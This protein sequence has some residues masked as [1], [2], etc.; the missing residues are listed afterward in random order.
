MY[1]GKLE[2]CRK[3]SQRCQSIWTSIPADEQW[4]PV[5][6]TKQS[7]FCRLPIGGSAH[8]EA[9]PRVLQLLRMVYKK[10]RILR[11]AGGFA[12]DGWRKVK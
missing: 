9:P 11:L 10:Q 6:K 1:T 12:R 5:M 7:A 8:V 4:K 3:S 2:N